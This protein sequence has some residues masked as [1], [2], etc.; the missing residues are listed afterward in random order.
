MSIGHLNASIRNSLQLLL[1]VLATVPDVID[2]DAG[3]AHAAMAVRAIE[4]LEILGLEPLFE[5]WDLV[6]TDRL[7]LMKYPCDHTETLQ[8]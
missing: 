3:L 5:A 1:H 7:R 4:R 6:T 8:A 2:K